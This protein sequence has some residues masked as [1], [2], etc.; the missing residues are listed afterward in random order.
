MVLYRIATQKPIRL[1]LIA[2]MV[3]CAT[4]VIVTS[5]ITSVGCMDL[6]P[7]AFSR[8]I[9]YS[10]DVSRQVCYIIF[11]FFHVIL[12]IAILW[13]VQISRW[14]K[15]SVVGLFMVGLM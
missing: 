2:D 8:D 6:S 10:T 13:N 3:I 11:D 15:L 14:M 4:W 7:W 12:P 9:C 1:I 5:I